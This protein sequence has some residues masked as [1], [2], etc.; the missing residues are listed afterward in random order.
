MYCSALY[1]DSDILKTQV[2]L[3]AI[4]KKFIYPFMIFH[5]E[6]FSNYLCL[7]LPRECFHVTNLNTHC[8]TPKLW[9]V[10]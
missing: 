10:G 7:K 9:L 1:I 6:K 2:F 4:Y 3:F 8:K 5:W